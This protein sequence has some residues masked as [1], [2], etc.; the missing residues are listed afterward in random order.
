MR[1][2]FE[3]SVSLLYVDEMSLQPAV[4]GETASERTVGKDLFRDGHLLP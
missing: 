2:L 1:T 3:G 4:H